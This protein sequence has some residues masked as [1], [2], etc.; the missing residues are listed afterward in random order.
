VVSSKKDYSCSLSLTKLAICKLLNW[1]TRDR[2]QELPNG[3]ITFKV[4][5][6]LNLQYK[7]HTVILQFE[8]VRSNERKGC[9]FCMCIQE[10]M[11]VTRTVILEALVKEV[12]VI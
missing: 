9:C 3:R 1:K 7:C 2:R 12:I 4:T 6:L 11:V 8:D 5:G 10:K